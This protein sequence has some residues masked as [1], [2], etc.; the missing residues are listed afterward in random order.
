MPQLDIKNQLQQGTGPVGEP[1]RANAWEIDIPA[2]GN[3]ALF[4]QEFKV[5]TMEVDA[6]E[7]RHFNGVAY[8]AGKQKVEGGSVKVRDVVSPDMHQSMHAWR[9]RVF[10]IESGRLGFASM[11]KEMGFAR[12]Y[13]S[14]GGLIRT[15]T[16][17]GLWPTKLDE[18]E[19]NYTNFEGVLLE[20]TLSCDWFTIA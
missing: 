18:G 3:V 17:N 1:V 20:V 2:L 16:L 9:K 5:A 4:A 14:L 8:I 19:F 13:D 15:Y 10:D 12:R 11:Y 7:I 6:M